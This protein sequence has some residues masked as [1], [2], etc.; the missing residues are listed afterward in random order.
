PDN[1][2]VDPED[3]QGDGGAPAVDGHPAPGDHPDAQP[4]DAV[5]QGGQ[6]DEE[7]AGVFVH[8]MPPWPP[9]RSI[10][11]CSRSKNRAAS[12]PS[13]WVWW[14]WK[15]RGSLARNHSRRQLPQIREA[16]V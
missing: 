16:E 12:A 10:S 13:I 11:A 1:G 15:D 4:A 3:H 2:Q 6:K 8:K 9:A 5:Q 7:G 14:N